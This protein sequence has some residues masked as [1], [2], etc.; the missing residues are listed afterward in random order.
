MIKRIAIFIL[1]LFLFL[2]GFGFITEQNCNLG[3]IYF[4]I[5]PFIVFLLLA[6]RYFKLKKYVKM[7]VCLIIALIFIS[8]LS[9]AFK[10]TNKMCLKDWNTSDEVK[11][12]DKDQKE[13]VKKSDSKKED[14]DDKKNTIVKQEKNQ[15]AKPEPKKEAKAVCQNIKGNI[16]GSGEKIYHMK[17]QAFYNK[18]DAEKTFCSEVEAKAAGFRKSKR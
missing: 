17:G 7:L 8:F 16:S 3:E 6:I 4:A 12:D 9:E 13:I 5:V 15:E 1:L 11:K 14:D 2:I 18:T 10:T